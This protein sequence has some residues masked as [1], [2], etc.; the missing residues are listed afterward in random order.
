MIKQSYEIEDWTVQL[1]FS[2]NIDDFDVV[3]EEL[4]E[5]GCPSSLIKK[6]FDMLNS[7]QKDTG[8][9]YSNFLLEKSVI[10]IG[11][12]SNMGELINTLIHE[13]FH[14]MDHMRLVRDYDDEDVATIIGDFVQL[15]FNNCASVFNAF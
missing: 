3:K 10:V 13:C 11:E 1:L 5:I 14:L 7:G 6:A 9:A 12:I 4:N 8:F 15:I 2:V